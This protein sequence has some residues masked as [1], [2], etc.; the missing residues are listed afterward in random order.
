MIG[1]LTLSLTFKVALDGWN[2][3]FT[4]GNASY[5]SN[6]VTDDLVFRPTYENENLEQVLVWATNT[7]SVLSDYKVI[8]EDNY[9]LCGFHSVTSRENPE[10]RTKMVY[11][12]LR[13]GKIAVYHCHFD[14]SIGESLSNHLLPNSKKID[15][16]E[17]L[18]I[19]LRKI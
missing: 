17:N 3:T 8:N 12:S 9:S 2:K 1:T 14:I 18:R 4:T 7:T 5:L 19:Y 15:P 10:K 11:A 13:N 6:I 16:Q